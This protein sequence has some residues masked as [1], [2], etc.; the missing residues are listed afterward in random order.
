MTLRLPSPTDEIWFRPRWHRDNRVGA[1]HLLAA[2]QTLPGG[3]AVCGYKQWYQSTGYDTT[4]RAALYDQ[5]RICQRC[6]KA[7]EQLLGRRA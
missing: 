2:G 1:W 5:A 6:S 3:R 7:L 4:V